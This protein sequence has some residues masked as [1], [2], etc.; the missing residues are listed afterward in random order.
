MSESKFQQDI[1]GTAV[2]MKRLMM[3]K[4][5]ASNWRQTTP[6]YLIDGSVER[7]RLRRVWLREYII[8]GRK[9]QATRVLVYVH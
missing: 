3:D 9:R 1:G 2:C 7:K 8:A 5:G 6:N 4:K